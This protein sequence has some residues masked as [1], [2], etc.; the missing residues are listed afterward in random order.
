MEG[1]KKGFLGADVIAAIAKAKSDFKLNIL[2]EFQGREL[3]DP[4]AGHR[5]AK[6]LE[7]Y[8]GQ[9]HPA[10]PAGK[11]GSR[12]LVLKVQSEQIAEMYF[13]D[14]HYRTGS[15]RRILDF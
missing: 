12:R 8:V 5:G 11:A 7:A 2:S 10:D 6:F 14:N 4:H 3:I 13:S 15:W 1:V 9:A